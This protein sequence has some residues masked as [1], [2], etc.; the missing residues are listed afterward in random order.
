MRQHVN[1]LSRFF[2]LPLK[3]PELDKL[4]VDVTLPIH[5]DIGSARGKF[6]LSMASLEPNWNY[7]GVDI[8]HQ[9]VLA[10]EQDRVELGIDNLRFLFCNANVSLQD[11][12]LNLPDGRLQRITIQFPDPWFKKRHYKR[13][14]FQVPLLI[15]LAG[16]LK[17][18]GELFIQSDLLAVIEPMVDLIEVSGCFNPSKNHCGNWL[19]TSPFLVPTE[20]ENYALGKHLPVYRVQYYRNTKSVPGIID[21]EKAWQEK[22]IFVN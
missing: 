4:F 14:V 22:Q 19:E 16:A 13:R 9:L 6:L 11:W 18:G 5:L 21:L 12:L 20:R 3:L 17:P 1:P 2:Q 7:L 8:R 10:A 15:S